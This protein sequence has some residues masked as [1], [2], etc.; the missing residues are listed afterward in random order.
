MED[1]TEL[2]LG[3][4]AASGQINCGL[5]GGIYV[6]CTS[7]KNGYDLVSQS[8]TVLATTYTY[9]TCNKSL[10]IGPTCPSE[11]SSSS[12]TSAGSGK[13]VRCKLMATTASCQYR[14]AANYY[15]DGTTCT[16]CGS[17]NGLAGTSSAGSTS[18]SSCCISSGSTHS[19][20]DTAGSG[21]A[22]ISST[23]CAS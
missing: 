14:C 15:G 23:C 10:I 12:W 7:C 20:S 11:C 13:E 5:S 9:G 1:W 22:T 18:A 2:P 17:Y 19:F 6:D 21:T 4:T 16:S 3:C 8:V